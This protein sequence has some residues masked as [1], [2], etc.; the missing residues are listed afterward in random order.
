M[1]R[2]VKIGLLG[3]LGAIFTIIG[4][5]FYE[6]V[7][8]LKHKQDWATSEDNP[9]RDPQ[10]VTVREGINAHLD[11]LVVLSITLIVFGVLMILM[12]VMVGFHYMAYERNKP[13]QVVMEE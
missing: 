5:F 1:S 4:V 2:A 8:Y 10:P 7:L 12:K 9:N 11:I 6:F 3:I 13:Q